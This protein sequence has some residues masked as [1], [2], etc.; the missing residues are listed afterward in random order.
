MNELIDA[1]KAG[2]GARVRAILDRTP[3][4]AA[5]RGE[6]GESALMAALYNGHRDLANQIADAQVAA[7]DSLDVFAAAALGRS[8]EL[9][10]ALADAAAATA[11]SYDGWTAL[12]LAAFFGQLDAA[13]RLLEAGGRLAA[14]S[15]NPLAN[16]PLHAAVAGRRAD[17]SVFLIER[18]AD[19]NATD[20]GG[21]TPLHIAAEDG[22]LPVVEALLSRNADP[23]A[24]DAEDKTPLS[25]A[26]ARNHTAVV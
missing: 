24:V 6:G 18:G 14:V 13:A 19:V 23:H 2:D 1:A 5:V 22:Q 8:S 21:H 4:S 15:R 20:S 12:H 10:H 3:S 7:G 16:T 26:A 9:E 11:Y 25:R 17:V